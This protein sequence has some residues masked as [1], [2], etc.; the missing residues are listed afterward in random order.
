MPRLRMAL[1]A[2]I[3]LMSAVLAG[4]EPVPAPGA[5]APFRILTW[6]IQ[7]GSDRGADANGWPERKAALRS[8]IEAEKPDVFCAQEALAGQ[9]EFLDGLL[10]KHSREGVGRDDGK[11]AGEHCAVYWDTRRFERLD[12]GTF[13]LNETPDKPGTAWGE[14]YNRICT[15]VRLKD[16]AS[17]RTL[18]VFNMHLP[19][20]A[21]AREKAA[22]L[23]AGR[24]GKVGKDDAVI[25]AG[26]LNSGPGGPAWKALEGCG[27]AGAEKSAGG[28]PGTAT[29][30]HKGIPLVCLD[31]IFISDSWAVKR[32][33]VVGGPLQK[34]YPSDHFGVAATLEWR[35]AAKPAP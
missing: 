32:H 14:Q 34:A 1:M 2:A 20:V 21:E 35:E 24:I 6:N 13:W 30:H 9:L 31:A 19:L 17:G 29:F 7:Y 5:A 18:R 8:A 27:L 22:G 15:W 26:D 3:A 12:G 11:K 10:P 23:V 33:R 4:E 16:K 25:A 28:K